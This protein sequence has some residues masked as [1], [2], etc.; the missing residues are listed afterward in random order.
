[1]IN[2]ED[3]ASID[4]LKQLYPFGTLTTF[5]SRTG[6]DFFI[7]IAPALGSPQQP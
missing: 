6:K 3:Q 5:P 7:F 2:P 1:L 4:V